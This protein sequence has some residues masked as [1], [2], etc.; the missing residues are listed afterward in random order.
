[1]GLATGLPG[2]DPR[3]WG[4]D[5]FMMATGNQFSFDDVTDAYNTLDDDEWQA[6]CI[7]WAKKIG[8]PI[9]E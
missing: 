7:D 2:R 1:M 8:W 9:P 5:D 3:T 6:Y 4:V